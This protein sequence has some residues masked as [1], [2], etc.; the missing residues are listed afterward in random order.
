MDDHSHG[1]HCAGTIA[2]VGNDGYGVAGVN[3]SSSVMALKF[4]SSSGSG[5]LSDAVRAVNYAT[6]M[7]TTYGVNI[8][9]TSNSWGGGSYSQSMYDAIAASGQAGIMF[10]AA[11]GNSGT[12]NDSSPHYPS[13]YSLDSVIAVA[14]S[15]NRDNLASFSCY[16]ASSVDLA[17]P[18]VSI[19]STVA[20][21]GYAYY[22]GTSMAT[23]HVSGVAA[24]AWSVDPGATVAEIRAAIL[25]GVDAKA[26]LSGKV[27][28]GGR[29]NARGT[30]ELLGMN[31][32]GSSPA[33]GSVVSSR[34][35]DFTIDFSQNYNPASLQASDLTVNGLAANS[36]AAVDAN[37]ARFHFNS[38]PLGS[39]GLQTMQIGAGAIQSSSGASINSWQATFYYDQ[40]VMAITSTNPSQ[41][42]VL[43]T[44]PTSITLNFN[45]PVSAGSVDTGDLVL[46]SGTVTAASLLDA[47]TIRYTVS[48]PV[49]DGNVT[50]LIS[51]GALTDTYGTPYHGYSGTFVVDDPAVSRY[52]SSDTPRALIDYGTI[53]STITV[54]DSLSI[55][56]LDVELDITHTWDEDLDVYLIAPNSTVI[57][58]FTDVGGSGDNFTQTIL[59]NEAGSLIRYAYAPFTGRFRPE[60]SLAAVNGINSAGNWTLKITDDYTWDSGTLNRWSLQIKADM[61]PQLA[62]I[63]DQTM[64][65][66]TDRLTVSL[67]ATDA[68]GDP[69]VFSVEVFSQAHELD[70][71]LG[72]YVDQARLT[73]NYY[74]NYFGHGEKHILGTGG[75]GYFILPNGE[76][77]RWAGSIAASPL[78][79]TLNT[80]YHADP[81]LLYNASPPGD[82][83]VSLSIDQVGDVLT[84]DPDTDYVGTFALKVTASDGTSSSSQHFSVTVTNQAPTLAPITDRTMSHRADQLQVALQVSNPDGDP[85]SYTATAHDLEGNLAY[86]LDQELG[87]YADQARLTNNYYY[88]YFGYGEKHILGAGGTGY[89]ILPNGQFYRWDGSIAHSTHIAT[90]DPSYH[91]DPTTLCEA[92][93]GGASIPA[94]V[95]G[96]TLTVDP[97]EGFTGDV[98]VTVTVSDG[99]ASDTESF[100]VHVAN[101]APTLAAIA[102]QTISQTTDQLQVALQVVDPDGDPLSYTTTALGLEENLAYQLD[103]E[104]GLYADQ[105]RLTNNYYYNYFGHGEKHILGTGGAG[106]FILPNG[107]FYRWGGSI[108]GST[109]IATLDP[110]HHANPATLYEAQRGGFS[111]PASVSGSTLTVDPPEGFTGDIEVRVTVSDGIASDTESFMVHVANQAP[112]LAAIADQAMSPATDSLTIALLASDPDGDP[113]TFSAALFSEAYELD[114]ELGLYA[115]Q[116]RLTNNYYYNYFGH[117][118]KH[119]LGTGGT[120]YFILPNGEFYHWGGSIE[121]S[122]LLATLQSVYHADPARLH[123]APAPGSIPV[124]LSID[125]QN[126]TLS[127][128]PDAGYVGSFTVKVT[129]SDGHAQA[130]ESFD[131]T[132]SAVQGSSVEGGRVLGAAAA[133]PADYTAGREAAVDEVLAQLDGIEALLLR[134]DRHTDNSTLGYTTPLHLH[135]PHLYGKSDDALRD[136]FFG[137]I[138]AEDSLRR[139]RRSR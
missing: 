99:I 13:S 12:N 44:P 14:A 116:A 113:I 83:P 23:P 110:S 41:G 65:H 48:V 31:V 96:S 24:L 103:Q 49:V 21:G 121:S 86:Q 38:S 58:L 114:Q 9:V 137:H 60:G 3:W 17:A 79:A 29:L 106:Y 104:L 134:L 89:F 135:D 98:H 40:V 52:Q 37:T 10:V 72:L 59:D 61:P 63:A 42:Q 136:R 43:A 138:G 56:D 115:D 74:Y 27:A 57:E 120:G 107:Q 112:V 68:E 132:V 18:G 127:I 77:H 26:S 50:Y 128:D 126:D 2:G 90:L 105:A 94:W 101:Q 109:Y 36:V 80:G 87:L 45:E 5:S 8:R 20:G 125:Q 97:P 47:D 84:I 33:D 35:T 100:V 129:A 111:V 91:A 7:R 15:D 119:I 62:P 1:T 93:P 85:L 78:I 133:R 70:Q 81:S 75:T 139:S 54:Q 39:D 122:T 16:G 118:E 76:F 88:N 11:A 51:S 67:D 108:A 117:G 69:I 130:A 32:A 46:S 28:T 6:M 71:Q 19:Y 82:I 30:L 131:V 73:N 66:A 4:L 102:D 22:N 64:H 34:I 92:E 55:L 53:Y 124:T 123:D 25:G 95:S